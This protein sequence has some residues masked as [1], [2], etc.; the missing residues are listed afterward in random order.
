V[1]SPLAGT[2]SGVRPGDTL[3]FALNGRIAAVSV[4]YRTPGGRLRFSELAGESAFRRGRNTARAFVVSG[5]RSAPVLREL[6]VAL[7]G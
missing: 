3:A 7:S 1:P 6:D 5:A 2:L 4:A